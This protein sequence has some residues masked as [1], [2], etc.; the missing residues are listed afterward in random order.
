MAFL[1]VS[2]VCIVTKIWWPKACRFLST[3]QLRS[4]NEKC[5]QV[6]SYG[7]CCNLAGVVSD[8]YAHPSG[9]R[10]VHICGRVFKVHRLVAFAFLG[11]PPSELAWQVHHRDGNSSNNRLDNLEYVTPRQN[12]RYSHAKGS[13]QSSGP[14]QSKPVMWRAVGSEGW[15]TS[16]SM[17]HAAEQV[18][19]DTS[20]V[21]RASRQGRPA[22]GFEFQLAESTESTAFVGEE[23]L[24]MYDPMSGT[25]VPGRMVSSFGRIRSQNGR[26]SQGHKLKEGYFQT[27]L[28]LTWRR[29]SESVHRLVAVAFLGRPAGFERTQ[30]NHKDGDKGNN[31]VEN[32]EYVTP[33]EN[34]AHYHANLRRSSC[35][36]DC[37]PVESRLEGSNNEWQFHPSIKSA[38]RL[39]RVHAG[40]ISPCTKGIRRHTGGYEF[41]LSAR[42]QAADF[43]VGEEWRKVDIEAH[44]CERAWRK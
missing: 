13:R 12:V 11:P 15:T 16:P 28:A 43:Y 1:Q 9:Y 29:R 31:A 38:A 21:S 19:M 5:W 24:Q 37:K 10:H 35:R 4:R 32:L 18:G 23:W 42:Q 25:A 30:V 34:S 33:A 44:L 17:T 22:K 7:R 36:S 40:N 27:Q 14:A 41:R 8:G 3:H 6:S 39:L 2:T 26:I 20:T